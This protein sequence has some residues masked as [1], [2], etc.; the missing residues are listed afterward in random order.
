MRCAQGFVWHILF[1][2]PYFQNDKLVQF[3]NKVWCGKNCTILMYV[4]TYVRE[5][6]DAYLASTSLALP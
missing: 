4:D 3:V 6:K 2:P 1:L 5:K